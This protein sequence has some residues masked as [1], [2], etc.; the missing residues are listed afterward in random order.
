M[1]GGEDEVVERLVPIFASIAPGVDDAP[2]TPGRDGRAQPGR[3]GLPALRPERRR[4][5]REDGAQ[6]HRVRADGRL[7]RGP[8]HHQERATRAS[9]SGRR[10]PRR[11]RSSIPSTTSTRSTRPRSPRSGGAAA[12]SA[13]GC[14]T[15][16]P[17]RC[18]SRPTLDGVRRPRLRLGRGPLDVDRRDRGGRPGAGADR[19]RSTPGSPR[20]GSTTSPT[21][22]LSAMRKE[23]GGHDEKKA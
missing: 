12:S 23:F 6:R 2:R 15:S 19:R 3:A 5:L 16:P 8:E 14:S 7:R 20:A 22:L 1:I 4:P 9:A 21:R 11:R 17:R 18:S 10:T 13:R